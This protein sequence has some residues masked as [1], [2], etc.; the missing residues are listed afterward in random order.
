MLSLRRDVIDQSVDLG[1]LQR[2]S[3]RGHQRAA[4]FHAHLYIFAARFQIAKRHFVDH[5]TYDT[6]SI[7]RLIEARWGL[8]PLSD[9]DA[10]AAGLTNALQLN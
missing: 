8:T 10:H 9:R 5:T 6:T 4:E 7:L 3:K 2:Q 1:V